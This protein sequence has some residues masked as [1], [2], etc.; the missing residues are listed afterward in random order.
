MRYFSIAIVRM[1][2]ALFIGLAAPA[3]AGIL[4]IESRGY[5][6]NDLL[7]SVEW[8]KE[9]LENEDVL[10][11][12]ARGEKAYG[13]GHIQGAIATSWQAF[14]K[15]K[16]P[17]GQGF[18]TLLE[19]VQLSEKFQELG[20]SDK[21]TI[22]VYADPDGWGEDGRIVWMLRMAKLDNTKILD[23]GWPAW[24]KA[25]G[26]ITKAKT[27]P[28]PS[29]FVMPAMDTDMLATT[30]WIVKNRQKIIALDT[31]TKREWDGARSYGE[32]RGGHIKDAIHVEWSKFFNEDKT[33]KTQSQIESIMKKAGIK[34]ED[35]IALYCTS[36]I[37]SAH[38]ALMLRMAGYANAKNYAASI[39]EWGARSQLPMEK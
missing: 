12:D 39:Y 37:R 4:P 36:G 23:G 26:K 15:M 10:V 3:Y 35:T 22:V 5:V 31:R 7:V 13:K 11:L 17:K 21:K 34:K 27:T 19:P 29:N 28:I 38:M 16:A 30:E 9:H 25:K 1:C 33:I 8:L 32:P 14:S 20:I 2:C 6:H 24:Q 18:A